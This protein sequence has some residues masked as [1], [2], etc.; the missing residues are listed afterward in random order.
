MAPVELKARI[1]LP[2]GVVDTRSEELLNWQT[3][4]KQDD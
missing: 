1:F 4:E 3:M 2:N